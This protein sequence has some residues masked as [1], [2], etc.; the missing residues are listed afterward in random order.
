ML[1]FVGPL[2]SIGTQRDL[3]IYQT[4]DNSH[5]YLFCWTI[6]FEFWRL[7]HYGLWRIAFPILTHSKGIAFPIPIYLLVHAI[8]LQ[9][10]H[11]N[12]E[13]TRWVTIDLHV[14]MLT[15][16]SPMCHHQEQY[17]QLGLSS[18][19]PLCSQCSFAVRHVDVGGRLG[20]L[21]CCI[22]NCCIC[23]ELQNVTDM[24]DISV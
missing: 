12:L 24:A 22:W 2:W 4:N 6:T 13:K 5:F 19:Y 21:H 8:S 23:T 11:P 18:L 20:S 15:V 14:H 17:D 10:H 16:F 7:G 9:F 3:E 1:W